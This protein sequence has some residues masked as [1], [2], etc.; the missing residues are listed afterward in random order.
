MQGPQVWALLTQPGP[1]RRS[2]WST[3]L[4]QG[5]MSA[6]QRSIPTV[7][8]GPA[9]LYTAAGPG[10]SFK[11]SLLFS[12]FLGLFLPLGQPRRPPS[13]RSVGRWP[14]LGTR[15]SKMDSEPREAAPSSCL[16]WVQRPPSNV[17]LGCM[18]GEEDVLLQVNKN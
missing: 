4:R 3:S 11:C 6:G 14:G 12:W 8:W 13:V 16:P 5:A 10:C 17:T 1:N 7:P 15:V 18:G 9:P 2:R